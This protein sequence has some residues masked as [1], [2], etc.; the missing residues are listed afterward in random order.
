MVGA[1]M[2]GA[3]DVQGVRGR[4]GEDGGDWFGKCLW[5]R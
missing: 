4:F 5:D 3:R 1:D 2:G